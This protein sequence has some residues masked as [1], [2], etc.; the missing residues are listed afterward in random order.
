MVGVQIHLKYA[1]AEQVYAKAVVKDVEH[2]NLWLGADV[3]LEYPVD[4]AEGLL[5][6]HLSPVVI[7][8]H[9]W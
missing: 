9:L 4:E 2:V 7:T 5:V 8:C 3:M 1:L 6:T